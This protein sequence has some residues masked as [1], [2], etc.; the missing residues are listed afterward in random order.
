VE[1]DVCK[2]EQQVASE[3]L[4]ILNE[5][6]EIEYVLEKTV[7]LL[8]EYL[9][10]EAIG[11]R[12]TD[13]LGNIPYQTYVGFTEGFIK[14]ESP[15]CIRNDRCACIEISKGEYDPTQP[16]YTPYGSFFTNELQGLQPLVDGMRAGRFRGECVRS[17]WESLALVPIRFGHKSFGLI[18]A[19][20]R[21]KGS[22]T[23]ER[24][25]FIENVAAQ[26]GLYMNVLGSKKDL[27]EEFSSL[28]K[29][30]MH[31]IRNPLFSTKMFAELITTKY[32]GNLDPEVM[33]FLSRISR[34]A[35]Y[36]DELVSGLSNF[37]AAFDPEKLEKKEI[38]LVRFVRT[39]ISDMAVPGNAEVRV[40]LTDD[41][42]KVSYPPLS[43]KRVLSNLL[44]NALKYSSNREA[45]EVVI[46]CEDKN[47]FYQI[48]V[49]D[50]GMGI[51]ESDVEKVFHPFY[52]TDD[53]AKIPGTGLGLAICKKIVEKNGGK[54]WV[55]SDKGKGSMFY[56]TVPK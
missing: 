24:V 43:L 27:E 20:D 52:R 47:I 3:I 28:V 31:D 9:K 18:H 44:A 42:Y 41:A 40:A 56:F 13:K 15:L 54:I 5:G 45:P 14:K 38:D 16:L 50:N 7:A 33:D 36:M 12:M 8:A 25:Q 6:R 51:D 1:I 34:N 55:Y 53:A 26:V 17:G 46:D 21:V 35:D 49:S 30:V 4:G 23:K 10:C 19:V 32:D 48:S 39:L 37:A 29:R 22:F 2:T 11:V